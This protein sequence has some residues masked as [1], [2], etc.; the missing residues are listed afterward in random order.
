MARSDQEVLEAELARAQ[1]GVGVGISADLS[2]SAR[3]SGTR[4]I[5]TVLAPSPL[6]GASGLA[7]RDGQVHVAEPLVNRLSVVR[8][9]GEVSR[10]GTPHGFTHPVD[11]AF[12][13]AGVEYV[14]TAEAGG[15]WRRDPGGHWR[16]LAPELS[17]LGGIVVTPAGDLVVAECAQGG[18]L[19]RVDAHDGRVTEVLANGLGCPGRL[20]VEDD[21]TL[22]VPLRESGQVISFDPVTKARA[23]LA[24]G[25]DIPVATGR[26]P[27]G[28]RIVLESGTGRILSLS[29][30]GP[31]AGR[32]LVSLPPGI[33]DVVTCGE[34]VIVSNEATGSL[35]AYNP[36]PTKPRILVKSGLVVPGGIVFDG[37]DLIV[38]DRA[39]IKRIRG[40][41]I[42]LLVLS[43]FDGMPPPVG[44]SGGLPGIVWIT[45][46]EEGELHQVDLGR[47]ETTRIASGLD[48]PT[49]VLRTMGGD[50]VVA[51]TGAGRIVKLGV[52]AVLYTMAS[53]LMSPVALA[54][55]GERILTAEPGGGRVLR[56]R[57]GEAP[58]VLASD[59]ASPAGLATARSQPLYIAEQHKGTVL[60]R[61]SDGS[62]RRVIEGLS[63]DPP[64][65]ERP[66][67]V[68]I[69]IG[70]DG[71]IVVAS[72]KDGSVVR[73]WPY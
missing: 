51:E 25:L 15:V 32:V 14:A 55:R 73:L 45:A 5:E 27:D 38:T 42:E 52:G 43:R 69:A 17:E 72:P 6:R 28:G 48:W 57:T 60:A 68:P 3:A 66:L 24:S 61:S 13:D 59:L 49:S 7:C 46:P 40:D 67:P 58:I 12:D 18:R 29:G 64:R 54:T 20:S 16:Q 50:L 56:I 22:L 10:I 31:N 44:L 21:G 26:T 65:G 9:T 47:A 4:R 30:S 2:H 33:A 8:A 39:S 35:H 34:T 1:A 41:K 11:L 62:Q 70:R 53:G 23:V 71:S 63:L 19:L 36:W 37:E